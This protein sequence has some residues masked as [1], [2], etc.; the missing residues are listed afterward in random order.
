MGRMKQ[1]FAAAALF[2]DRVRAARQDREW[3]Q[4]KLAEEAGLHWTY[5]S[6]CERGERNISLLN[7]LRVAKALG[8]NP[9]QLVDGLGP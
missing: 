7:I 6:S 1:P 3:S 2:G 9:S 8:V 4:E 5:I